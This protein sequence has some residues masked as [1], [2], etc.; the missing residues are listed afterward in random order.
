MVH[1]PVKTL[2]PSLYAKE[3][4]D[5]DQKQAVE[6]KLVDTEK[7]SYILDI[8]IHSLKAGVAIKYNSFLKVMKDSKDS[9]ANE[10]VKRLGRLTDY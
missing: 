6:A 1:L 7:M 3:V 8:I 4:I 9:V 2:L 5:F 10:T